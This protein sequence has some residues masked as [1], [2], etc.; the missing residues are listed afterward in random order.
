ML[1]RAIETEPA[2]L[3]LDVR[4]SAEFKR[5]HIAGATM[6]PLADLE[7]AAFL[8]EQAKEHQKV[9][10]ICQSGARAR[11]AIDAF[12]KAGF[13]N[14]ALVKGGME[15]WVQAGLPVERSS[16]A[17]LPISQQVQITVGFIVAVGSLLTLIVHPKFVWIPLFM[18][19]GLIFAG[20]TGFCGLALI[21]ARMPWNRLSAKAGAS[22][23][24]N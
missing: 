23:T 19:C 11:K 22:C 12:E 2:A 6:V 3:L 4:T 15:A 17:G 16:S 8:K 1:K 14:C 9:F 10:V 13:S 20:T 21:L 7:P 24:R 18:G 5:E